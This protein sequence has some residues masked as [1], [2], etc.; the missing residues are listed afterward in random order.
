MACDFVGKFQT[1]MKKN[2]EATT[3]DQLTQVL[4]W[5]FF[6]VFHQ[7]F[8]LLIC[9]YF[10][11][12]WLLLHFNNTFNFYLSVAYKKESIDESCLLNMI[13]STIKTSSR[14]TNTHSNFPRS[15]PYIFMHTYNILSVLL[16]KLL[17]AYARL[18][19]K[20]TFKFSH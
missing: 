4:R 17:G 5:Q 16:P 18:L 15:F 1:K 20:H 9:K 7:N 2:Q 8:T 10:V 19:N 11:F 3:L 12:H 6:H 14:L 13:L